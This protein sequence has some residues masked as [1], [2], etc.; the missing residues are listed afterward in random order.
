[1]IVIFD[2]EEWERDDLLATS[3][4]ISIHDPGDRE[5]TPPDFP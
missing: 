3:D 2:V 5:D 1:M 4:V